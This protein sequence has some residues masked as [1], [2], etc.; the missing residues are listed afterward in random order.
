MNKYKGFSLSE[1]KEWLDYNPITGNFTW[2]KSHS[3]MPTM[4]NSIA[5][6]VDGVSV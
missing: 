3:N 6:Y 2:L 1:L 5:R 4:L